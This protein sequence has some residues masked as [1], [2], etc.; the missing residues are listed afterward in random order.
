MP[1]P[2]L[3]Q[4]GCRRVGLIR[5]QVGKRVR[6]RAIGEVV[7][8]APA[9][10]GDVDSETDLLLSVGVGREVRAVEMIFGAPRIGL[11]SASGE[12][13]GDCDLQLLVNAGYLRIVVSHQK[14][15]LVQPVRR[16]LVQVTDVNL[17]LEK[18]RV[19]AGRG[20]RGSTHAL[21]LYRS[22]L[23]GITGPE[24]I[25]VGEIMKD[26]ARAEEVMHGIGH[27][28][29]AGTEA[30]SLSRRERVRID[31]SL[32]IVQI[33][34]QAQQETGVLGMSQRPGHRSLVVL[35]ALRRLHQGE[36]VAGIESGI[37]KQEI[38]L[39]VKIRR[40]ALGDQFQARAPRPG[41]TRRVRILIDPDLLHSG[42]SDARTV[43]LDSIDYQRN[44]VGPDRAVVQKP[45]HGR[46]VVLIEYRYAVKR[47]AV[48]GVRI[49]IFGDLCAD[50]RHGVAR[51]H[52]D[53]FGLHRDRQSDSQQVLPLGPELG[54]QRQI[55]KTLCLELESVISRRKIFEAE[56]SSPIRV[57]PRDQFGIGIEKGHLG[58]RN[59]G[60]R[61][62]HQ[63]SRQRAAGSGLSGPE[64]HD[65]GR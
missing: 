10:V 57:L 42:R 59:G 40:A 60:S 15:Q 4:I 29:R 30:G 6:A 28:L 16:K 61:W 34:V 50:Q 12:Q 46:D 52:G 64:R 38:Q 25:A 3:H 48:D 37:A 56:Q 33:F 1:L 17:V 2:R 63:S 18:D 44:S 32:L 21:I 35:T 8:R 65:H 19:G 53:V 54:F 39:A 26:A 58:T 45:R 11:R 24:L 14:A 62:I 7:E 27:D 23:V 20:Q 55:A 5:R 51:G 31:D 41:K 13:S 47:V 9:D 49:L 43:R 22:V 36:R